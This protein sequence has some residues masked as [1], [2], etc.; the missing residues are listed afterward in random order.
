[1]D[2]Y[3]K[4]LL[5]S[6][7]KSH[8]DEYDLIELNR[9]IGMPFAQFMDFIDTVVDEGLIAY[10][11]YKLTLTFKGRMKLLHSQMEYYCEVDNIEC[12]FF[13]EKWNINTPYLV[14]TFSKKK[15]RD[16]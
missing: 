14:R 11:N 7:F 4:L 3:L 15:W 1:M 16:S 8:T 12:L 6:Y 5:L 13:D 2:E 10:S 9:Q